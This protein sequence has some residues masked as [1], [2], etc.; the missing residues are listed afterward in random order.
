MLGTVM[1]GLVFGL[2]YKD[3]R[4]PALL[5]PGYDGMDVLAVFGLP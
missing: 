3:W 5:D 1:V 2:F 4:Y